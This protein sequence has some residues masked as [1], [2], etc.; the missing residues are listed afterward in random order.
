[1]PFNQEELKQYNRQIIYQNW[2]IDTQEK[3]KKSS[4]FVAGAGGLGSPVSLYLSAVGI[5]TINICDFDTVDLSNLNRQLLHTHQ[6]VQTQKV[7]SA[8]RT[9]ESRNRHIIVNAI[10]AKIEK[11]N[12]EALIDGADIVLDCMD[13]FTTRY[14][15]AD[16]ANKKGI[17]FIHGSIWGMEGRVTV[18]H[19]PHTPCL[20]CVFPTA[21]SE[22]E[23]IPVIGAT[24]GV[25]GSI[26]AMEAIKIL[27]GIGSRLEGKLLMVDCFEMAFRT[28]NLHHNNH[29]P[30]CNC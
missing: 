30:V 7:I 3:I 12:A 2:G 24:A 22:D 14:Y 19:P 15:L 16:A 6:T 11:D 18:I 25:V 20:C 13:N 9:L 8:K 17:P 23:E 10:N 4:V 28:F 21:P 1:M 27:S 5:G 26:Q 29:C